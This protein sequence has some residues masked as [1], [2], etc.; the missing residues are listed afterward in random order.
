[1]MSEIPRLRMIKSFVVR[2]GRMTPGQKSAFERLATLYCI[3]TQ[4]TQWQEL[5]KGFKEIVLEIGF[6]MG[7]SVIHYAK[8]H[9]ETLY[10]GI[11]VHPPGVGRLMHLCEKEQ[12]QNI[13]IIQEDAIEVLKQFVPDQSLS[14]LHLFFPDPWPKARHHKRRIVNTEFANLVSSKLIPNGIF[15]LATDWE[16]YAEWML[17][18]LQAHSAFKEF[19]RVRGI[20]PHT[21]FEQRGIGLGHAIFDFQYKKV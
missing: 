2:Q 7:D 9:P 14:G 10:I 21:K 16:N 15:H 4:Q 20:R 8:A 3:Q 19:S 1:M 18:V 12:I 17:K 6:G 13:R 11:E 5:I